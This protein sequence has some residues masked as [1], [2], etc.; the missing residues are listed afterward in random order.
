MAHKRK[1]PVPHIRYTKGIWVVY[2]RVGSRQYAVST[3]LTNQKEHKAAAEIEAS[4][5][6]IALSKEPPA[7]PDQYLPAGAVQRYLQDSQ[8]AEQ[9]DGGAQAFNPIWLPDFIKVRQS[10]VDKS[11]YEPQFAML[12]KLDNYV[13]GPNPK[14]GQ[15]GL[16]I[17]TPDQARNFLADLITVEKLKPARRNRYLD[18]CNVFFKWA[19]STK[20][21]KTNPFA[22][23][24]KLTEERSIDIVYLT[25]TEQ[26]DLLS[27][28]R[29]IGGHDYFALALAL[30]MG[31]RL[32]EIYR[33]QWDDIDFRSMILSV[34]KSKTKIGRRIEIPDTLARILRTIPAGKRKGPVVI[35]PPGKEYK[36]HATA[37]VDKLR[38]HA[39]EKKLNVPDVKHIGWNNFRHTHASLLKQAGMS[40]SLISARLGNSEEVVDLFYAN[41]TARG[42]RDP[43]LSAVYEVETVATKKTR[44]KG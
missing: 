20:R 3:G 15:R 26:D 10:E 7:F 38:R 5:F 41:A 36:N 24:Q 13:K 4:R 9:E 2:W 31:M 8:Q 14:P 17:T 29:D 35:L 34:R 25:K 42:K 11:T 37:Y 21:R 12:R 16:E 33:A 22:A 43:F 40:S 30:Y 44:R 28:A 32:G 39:R 1:N 23:I 6:R 18:A 19:V 27:M